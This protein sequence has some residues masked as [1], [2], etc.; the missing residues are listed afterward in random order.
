MVFVTTLKQEGVSPG[1]DL[2]PRHEAVFDSRRAAGGPV[3]QA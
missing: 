1:L 3:R 2:G